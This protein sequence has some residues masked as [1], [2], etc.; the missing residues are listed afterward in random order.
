MGKLDYN[1]RIK[2]E[3]Q[4]YRQ[5]FKH[6]LFQEVPS[7][8]SK[9]EEKFADLIEGETG[10]RGLPEYIVREMKG[11]KQIRVLSLGS[12]SCGVELVVLAPRL[13]KIGCSMKLTSIDINQEVLEQAGSEA[14][15]RGVDF[16]SITQDINKLKLAPNTYDVI[17]AFAALHHF[18]K[19]DHVSKEINSALK[20]NGIFV[21]IDI[22]SRN[23][24]RLWDE[25][26]DMIGDLWK[27]IPSRYKWD[28]TVS[29]IPV[30]MNE[31]PD[32]DYSINSFECA[33]S[34]D[35]LPALRKNLNERV[36]VPA[37]AIARRFFDTKFGPN[38]NLKRKWD[39]DF[40]DFVM[41]LDNKLVKSGLLKPETFFGVYTKRR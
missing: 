6:R 40:F 28:H 9:V 26:K 22:P 24:Y 10:V 5:I 41:K 17:M 32:V 30:Y 39:L 7:I 15:N 35:I 12:G 1:D 31:Y 33:R 14:K 2:N 11:K 3:V 38:Y 18:E 16:E 21:T 29:K 20:P 13:A 19:L 4:H 8:W 27:I 37:L 25:S 36:Y 23:G 34:E